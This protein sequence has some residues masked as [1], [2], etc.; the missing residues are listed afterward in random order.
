[1]PEAWLKTRRIVCGR[2]DPASA[3]SRVA[4]EMVDD[5]GYTIWLADFERNELELVVSENGGLRC[6]ELTPLRRSARLRLD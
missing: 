5:S 3:A 6:R 1:V 4:V 2:Y